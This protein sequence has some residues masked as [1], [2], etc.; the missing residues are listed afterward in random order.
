MQIKDI[1]CF[2]L[3]FLF[4]LFHSF[5]TIPEIQKQI[6]RR[7]EKKIGLRINENIY[8]RACGLD[9]FKKCRNSPKTI[10]L[11][12][13]IPKTA[14]TTMFK[15]FSLLFEKP[16]VV[17]STE[18]DAQV[19][20][21]RKDVLE[22]LQPH[23]AFGASLSTLMLMLDP[24]DPFILMAMFRE[25]VEL[26]KSLYFYRQHP[27]PSEKDRKSSANMTVNEFLSVRN[28]HLSMTNFM[29]AS[30]SGI[31]QVLGHYVTE[32]HLVAA[33]KAIPKIFVMLLSDFSHGV[34]MLADILGWEIRGNMTEHF[35]T[36]SNVGTRHHL[37][38]SQRDLELIRTV[39]WCDVKLYESILKQY[40]IVKKI[41]A[42]HFGHQ[43]AA[44]VLNENPK[45]HIS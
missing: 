9:Y 14:G 38:L 3:S 37:E 6:E 27:P 26:R 25:P 43:K 40:E 39:N 19:W 21:Q 7:A 28:Q 30:L 41:H 11:Y 33:Q 2:S 35:S 16:F 1:L 24:D 45:D 22:N 20:R 32:K 10:F 42:Q 29:C 15:I 31:P 13:H 44:K 18:E 8:D 4:A 36:K 12:W 5:E 34:E 17:C 23:L